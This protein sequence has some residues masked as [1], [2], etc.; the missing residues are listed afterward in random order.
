MLLPPSVHLETTHKVVAIGAST[1]GTRAIETVLRALPTTTP[2][3]VI[4]QHMPAHFTAAFAKRLNQEC[5]MEVREAQEGDAVLPGVALVAPGNQHM[6]LHQNGARYQVHLKDG[7]PVHYQR[8]SVDVLFHSVARSAGRNAI[9]VLLTGMGADGAKGLL[10]MRESGA[11]TLAEDEAT[12]VVFGMPQEAIK[13]G[14]ATEI[15]PLSRIAQTI[16]NVVHQQ[17]WAT[18]QRLGSFMAE[19]LATEAT[20]TRG[21]RG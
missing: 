5:R 12:C 8:P 2:G 17:E 14:A 15:V 13:L 11:H 6:L 3:T 4:V 9:G 21:E 18:S 7:P 10:A 1:G 16:L 19:A 20:R